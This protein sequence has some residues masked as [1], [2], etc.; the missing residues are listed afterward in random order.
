MGV[1]ALVSTLVVLVIGAF[2]GIEEATDERI[3]AFFTDELRITPLQPGAAPDAFFTDGNA[4]LA[5]FQAAGVSATGRLESTY[6]LSRRTLLE[7][8]QQ[9]D[10][11]FRVSVPGVDASGRD[12]Y[13]VGLIIGLDT[14]NPHA[15]TDLRPYR[16]AGAMPSTSPDDPE[17]VPLWMSLDRFALTLSPTERANMTWPPTAAAMRSIDFEITLARLDSDSRFKD[18]IRRPAHVV[19]LFETDLDALDAFTLIAPIGHVRTLLGAE[20]EA[21]LYN[22]MTADHAARADRVAQQHGW[23]TETPHAFA[24]RYVGQIVDVIEF[25]SVAVAVLLYALPAFLLFVGLSQVLDRHER[26]V[27]VCR[28]I[29]VPAVALR[30]AVVRLLGRLALASLLLA[31]VLFLVGASALAVILPAWGGSPVP[32]GFAVPW[33]AYAMTITLTLV[34]GGLAVWSTVRQHEAVDLAQRLRAA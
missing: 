27:A 3:Q 21:P 33:W 18:V 23:A 9:E 5:A 26:E 22:V 25:L 29:G 19:G 15:T 30:A 20:P 32:L 34:V 4:T 8:Y 11:Q 14:T 2:E 31:A 28:A 1:L 12:F 16:M 10:D 17:T 7:S 13:G 24:G 6:L